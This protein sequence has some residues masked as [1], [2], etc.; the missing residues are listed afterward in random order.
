MPDHRRRMVPQGVQTDGTLEPRA[1]AQPVQDAHQ[2]PWAKRGAGAGDQQEG[3]RLRVGMHWIPGR[4]LTRSEDRCDG[5]SRATYT[6][7]STLRQRRGWNQYHG[8]GPLRTA[9]EQRRENRGPTRRRVST[10]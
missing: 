5:C 3:A 6:V 9:G 10:T 2:R 7:G 4:M 8:R 1:A